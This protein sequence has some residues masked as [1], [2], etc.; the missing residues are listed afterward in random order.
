MN[1]Y[2]KNVLQIF[3]L[4]RKIQWKMRI[5]Y[6]KKKNLRLKGV[7]VLVRVILAAHSP[8]VQLLDDAQRQRRHWRHQ[9]QRR[10][11]PNS[12]WRFFLVHGESGNPP[13]SIFLSIFKKL[14]K[15]FCD[16][17]RSRWPFLIDPIKKKK[18]GSHN[19]LRGERKC[20]INKKN[21][22]YN[23]ILNVEINKST[24]YWRG[25]EKIFIIV[26]A[27]VEF[28]F[29]VICA[30]SRASWKLHGDAAAFQT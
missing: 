30:G 20:L 13:A 7:I 8:W 23:E 5:K 27:S 24:K 11:E 29:C 16:L 15:C 12:K 3:F 10:I 22:F 18:I 9:C 19:F 21:C 1:S 25:V 2:H 6:K 4:Y 14:L 26:A 28:C 17:D